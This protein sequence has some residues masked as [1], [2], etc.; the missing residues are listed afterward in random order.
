MKMAP[1]QYEF[2]SR[3]FQEV[4]ILNPP[5]QLEYLEN[6]RREHPE[7][8]EQV[9]RMIEADLAAN[10]RKFMEAE[11]PKELPQTI[12]YE[13]DDKL[14]SPSDPRQPPL[15]HGWF[16]E[17]WRAERAADRMSVC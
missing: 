7:A 13:A 11:N 8:A 10:D 1:K 17:S 16:Q 4:V 15:T 14:R 3:H 12:G 2:I 5:Q 6:L 9:S